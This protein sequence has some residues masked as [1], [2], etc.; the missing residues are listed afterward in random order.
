M[1]PPPC[2]AGRASGGGNAACLIIKPQPAF[3]DRYVIDLEKL[4]YSYPPEHV[5]RRNIIPGY[6]TTIRITQQNMSKLRQ[7]EFQSYGYLATHSS[8]V[9]PLKPNDSSLSILSTLAAKLATTEQDATKARNVCFRA[10][11]TAQ[12]TTQQ[13]LQL[14]L[15]IEASRD[16]AQNHAEEWMTTHDAKELHEHSFMNS[17]SYPPSVDL[18]KC[19][20]QCMANKIPV[21]VRSV[22]PLLAIANGSYNAQLTSSFPNQFLTPTPTLPCM[23]QG[24]HFKHTETSRLSNIMVKTVIQHSAPVPVEKQLT[25]CTLL[26]RA[27]V[28]PHPDKS[29]TSGSNAGAKKRIYRKQERKHGMP[30]RPFTP[31][32]FSIFL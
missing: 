23:T 2:S 11:I 22:E 4:T 15:Q 10:N 8:S 17:R 26:K 21:F 12:K 3:R 25:N 30:R 29:T 1:H 18:E 28:Q 9:L 6:M 16:S 13:Y 5:M 32:K 20:H 7:S 31:C 14:K 19:R 24:T 27:K